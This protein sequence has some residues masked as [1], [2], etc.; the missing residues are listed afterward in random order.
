MDNKEPDS[1]A[2]EALEDLKKQLHRANV[3][4]RW[5]QVFNLEVQLPGLVD[6]AI[7]TTFVVLIVRLLGGI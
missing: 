5:Y 1:K 6:L 4:A 3:R 7:K 2:L